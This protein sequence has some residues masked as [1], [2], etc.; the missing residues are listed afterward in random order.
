MMSLHSRAHGHLRL[1]LRT[2][3]GFAAS[4]LVSCGGGVDS[5]GTGA[6]ALAFASGTITGFGSVIVNGVHFDDRSA[7][8]RDGD[9]NVRS[10]DDLRLGM[11]TDVRGSAIAV[12]VTG[13]RASVASSIVFASEIVGAVS[14]SDLAARSLVV[15]GQTIDI[16]VTTVFDAV[17]AGGQAALAVGNVVEIH[18]RL[19][20]ASGHYV[21]TRVE[22]RSA[23]AQY[24]L[25]GIVSN[26][27]QPARTFSIG[28]TRVAYATLAAAAVPATLAD[29]RFVRVSLALAP[30]AGSV[31]NATRIVDGA[32]AIDDGE[33]AHVEGRVSAFASAAQFSVNGTPVDARNAQFPNGSAGLALG[34]RVEVEGTLAAGVLVARSVEVKSEGGGGGG[35]GGGGEEYDVGGTIASLDTAAKTFVVRNVVVSYAGTVDFRDGTAADLAVGR[36]VEARGMLSADG[37]RLLATRIDIKR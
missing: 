11:S 12:D 34:R 21:A 20:A 29:G 4:L 2:A 18:A 23:V 6:P 15:L 30:G 5:G 9:G 13:N 24:A 7:A 3:L 35:G 33:Q 22:R 16:T 32:A 8:V 31:W 14:A 37:T 36:E 26:L 25:R 10:R 28:A 27:N 1:V 17:L 19:D